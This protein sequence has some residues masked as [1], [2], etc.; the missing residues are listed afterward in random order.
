M[1]S[2]E[3]ATGRALTQESLAL[4][5]DPHMEKQRVSDWERGIAAPHHLA[6][7]DELVQLVGALAAG[8]ALRTLEHANAFLLAGL[9]APLQPDEA[10]RCGLQPEQPPL[11]ER[12]L[13]LLRQRGILTVGHFRALASEDGEFGRRD[14]RVWGATDLLREVE[15][16]VEGEVWVFT[17][18]MENDVN[19]ARHEEYG[20]YSNVHYVARNLARGVTYLFIAPDTELIRRN[21]PQLE[22][23]HAEGR[24]RLRIVLVPSSDYPFGHFLEIAVYNPTRVDGNPPRAFLQLAIGDGPVWQVSDY[25][26]ELRKQAAEHLVATARKLLLAVAAAP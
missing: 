26:V 4:R 14:P 21:V 5:I 8:G 24:R 15:Q 22:Q 19:Q 17:P 1:Q 9:Y 3:P 18:H 11:D 23:L 7:R 20:E 12:L 13:T 16:Y 6:G 25:W 10:A 2:L